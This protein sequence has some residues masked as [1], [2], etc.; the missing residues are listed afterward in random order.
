MRPNWDTHPEFGTALVEAEKRGVK[1][2]AYQ[3]FVSP[4]ELR[5]TVPVII[6]LTN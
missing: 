5:I 6:D 2:H 4:N 3:C 1:L